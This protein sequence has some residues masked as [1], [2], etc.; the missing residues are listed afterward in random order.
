MSHELEILVRELAVEVLDS[1]EKLEALLCVASSNGSCPVEVI[2]SATGLDRGV[3]AD[4]LADLVAQG[5]L[6]ASGTEYAL[7]A[8]G[9][10][11][12]HVRALVQLQQSDRMLVVAIMSQAAV[13]RL[14]L[15][16]ERAFAD[17]FLVLA[18]KRWP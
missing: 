16:A 5:V 9:P 6:V 15:R 3:L 11:S 13:R 7:A 8:D 14:R 10:W 12:A 4:A 17:A 18:R 1:F 2:V